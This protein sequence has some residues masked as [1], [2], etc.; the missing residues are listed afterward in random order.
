MSF[1][2]TDYTDR[3]SSEIGLL[4]SEAP[5]PKRCLRSKPNR[6]ISY[7]T[8]RKR[9]RRFFQGSPLFEGS[10]VERLKGKTYGKKE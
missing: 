8:T 5:V 2:D 7:A 4:I 10:R 3:F 9:L 6:P 1:L